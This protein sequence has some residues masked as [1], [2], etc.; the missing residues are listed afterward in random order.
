MQNNRKRP[1]LGAHVSA[2]GGLSRA[3]KNA[4]ELGTT[5]VI[6]IF[7][8]SPRQWRTK[9]PSRADVKEYKETL[10]KSNVRSVYLHAAYLVNLAAADPHLYEKS[11][12]N[13]SAHLKI[14]ELIG[15]QGLVFHLG[16][17]TDPDRSSALDRVIGGIKIVL[18]NVPG[19]SRLL[20]ENS[21]GGGRKVG[22]S[23]EEIG[24]LLRGVPSRRIGV[25]LDTAHA[26]E[27]G[28]I[29][30]TP[31]S[32]RDFLKRWKSHIGLRN[33]IVVHANDSQTPFASGVDRHENIG[34]GYIGLKGFGNLAKEKSLWKA[35]WILE[36]PGFA[37]NGPDKK[38]L[39]TL[40]NCFK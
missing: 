17:D 32:I 31:K 20:M 33:L 3:I 35:D 22:G 13:L 28:E 7:G 29:N 34:R 37:N 27:A 11:V 36:V 12:E 39:D 10:K 25:C 19:R 16:S 24:K 15:A 23:P 9:L 26:Y 2:A 18:K 14:T 8:A 21:S 38:N 6:Q 40:R 5:E 4:E 30:Y 1:L